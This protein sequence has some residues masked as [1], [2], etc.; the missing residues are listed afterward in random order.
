MGQG[1]LPGFEFK[2]GKTEFVLYG[3]RKPKQNCNVKIDN[4]VINQ[5]SSYKYLG[6]TLDSTLNLGDHYS[7][8]KKKISSRIK[9]LRMIRY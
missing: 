3:A 2:K 5:S 4:T 1:K 8:T 9:L 7:A 6:V